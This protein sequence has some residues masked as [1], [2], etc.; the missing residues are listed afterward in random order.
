MNCSGSSPRGL[1]CK[2]VPFTQEAARLQAHSALPAQQH[3]TSQPWGEALAAQP[4]HGEVVW[5]ISH[6]PVPCSKGP[7]RIWSQD[8]QLL[9]TEPHH[10]ECKLLPSASKWVPGLGSIPVLWWWHTPRLSRG[11]DQGPRPLHEAAVAQPCWM[12][13]LTHPSCLCLACGPILKWAV[14]APCGGVSPH[15]GSLFH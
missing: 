5:L 8:G 6:M 1:L 11:W 7:D 4:H 3:C 15:R 9:P 12:Q 10:F 14:R 2:H 13:G